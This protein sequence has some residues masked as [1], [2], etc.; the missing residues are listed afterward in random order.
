MG[1][2]LLQMRNQDHKEFVAALKVDTDAV[3]LLE[4]AIAALTKFYTKNKIPMLIQG[5]V[6]PEYTVDPDKAP[7]TTWESGNYGGRQSESTGLIAILNMIKEDLEKE[8][9]TSQAEEAQAQS[10]F[11]KDEA[12]LNKVIMSHEATLL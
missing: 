6:D 3:Q 4:M 8:I 1:K 11:K 10:D 5:K 7:E 9:Q 12:A 2:T